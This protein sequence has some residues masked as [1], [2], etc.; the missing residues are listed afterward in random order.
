[1]ALQIGSPAPDFELK[2]QHGVPTSLASFKGKKS[3]VVL[4][5]PL[6]SSK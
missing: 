2:D 5:Y 1:M 3:V 4:F 6:Y